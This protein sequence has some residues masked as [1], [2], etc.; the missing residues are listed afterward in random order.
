MAYK[1]GLILGMLIR[2]VEA[3]CLALTGK[4]PT[5]KTLGSG[6]ADS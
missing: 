3:P 1:Q 5:H 4:Q 2:Q 6:E